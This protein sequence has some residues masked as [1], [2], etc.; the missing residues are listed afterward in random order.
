MVTARVTYYCDICKQGHS[1]E[2]DAIECEARG[3]RDAYPIGL[4]FGDHRKGA[5]YQH[6]T[7]AVAENDVEGHTNHLSL[8]ACREHGGDSLGEDMCGYHTSQLS[9]SDGYVNLHCKSTKRLIR[10]LKSQGHDILIWNGKQIVTL[11]EYSR[12]DLAHLK[13]KLRELKNGGGE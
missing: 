4:I 10:W 13:A 8:W 9:E 3:V 2:E 6:I 12:V 7:F 1:T 11:D 5:F